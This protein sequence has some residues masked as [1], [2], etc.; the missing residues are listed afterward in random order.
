MPVLQGNT[1]GSIAGI[2]DDI[3]ST[4]KSFY[5]TN[6]TG[7]SVSVAMG[8]VSNETGVLVNLLNKDLSEGETYTSNTPILMLAGYTIYISV[9]GSIDYYFS[10]D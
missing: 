4:I 2:P 9:S 6:M 10:I 7:G 5:V 8:V 3:P 1:S